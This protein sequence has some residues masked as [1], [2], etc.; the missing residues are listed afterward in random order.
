MAALVNLVSFLFCNQ[1]MLL[2]GIFVVPPQKIR[3]MQF[4]LVDLSKAASCK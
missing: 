4:Q 1:L 3:Q 2:S